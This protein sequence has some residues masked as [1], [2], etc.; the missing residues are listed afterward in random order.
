MTQWVDMKALDRHALSAWFMKA[1]KSS[2][3]RMFI[4]KFIE[5][6]MI[7]I[8][9]ILVDIVEFKLKGEFLLPNLVTLRIVSHQLN[10]PWEFFEVT[11]DF[12]TSID[13]VKDNRHM[14]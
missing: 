14:I 12:Y 11:L 1:E 6:Y 10:N 8:F 2:T 5:T 3:E 9:L 13:V 7:G 4:Q